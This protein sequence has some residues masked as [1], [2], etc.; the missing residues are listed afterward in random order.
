M[1]YLF[2]I[3]VLAM[4]AVTIE[5][6]AVAGASG[7]DERT[8]QGSY[9][10]YPAPVTGCNEPLGSYACLSVETLPN[11]GS[12]TATV[13]DTHGQPVFVEVW[14]EGVMAAAFCG[15][16]AGPVAVEPASSLEFH[17]GLETWGTPAECP[18][19]RVKTS[20]TISVT[21]YAL[22]EI[23]LEPEPRAVDDSCPPGEIPEDGFS[24]V[25]TSNPHESAI[26]CVVHWQVAT[27]KSSTSYAPVEPVNRE[28]MASFIA[29]LVQ[30][31]GGEL[32]AASRDYFGDDDTSAHQDSINRLAQAG[33]VGGKSAGTYDPKGGVTRA[34]MA[35]LLA[36]AYDYRAAQAG[37]GALPA[38][39]NYFADDDNHPLQAEINRTAAAGFTGGFVD[40]SYRPLAGVRRDQMASFLTRVLDL[41]VQNGMAGVP[42]PR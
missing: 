27:G 20:G 10:P 5:S 35:A 16:T 6:P 2:R 11:E 37:Q 34:Q 17:V 29:R 38:G 24:D 23:D 31:S 8:V 4:L 3:V 18:A 21:L 36:R 9:G 1:R 41:V 25:P 26:D 28:Q 22:P 13:T 39:G 14:N 19:H 12:F 32:P 42:A 7:S 15:Q 40:G 33:I 30:R